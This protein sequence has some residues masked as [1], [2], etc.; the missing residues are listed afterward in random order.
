MTQPTFAGYRV[1]SEL[2]SGALSTV[3]K[4]TQDPLGRTV[5]I[6]VLKTT[7][8][9]RS[10]FA[11]QLEREAHVL[12]SLSHP[13]VAMLFDFVKS[14]SKMYLVLEYVDGYS[15]ADVAAKVSRLAPEVVAAIGVEIANGLAHAHARGIVHRDVK[16]ANVILSKRGDVKIA[17][18]G[19]AQRER[20]PSADEPL[21][22]IDES[23]AFGTPAYMSPEQILGEVVDAR[24]DIF[25]LGVVLYQL[26]CGARPFERGD[27][28]DKRA[29]AQRIR[30]DPPIPLHRRAPEVPRALERIV[31]RMVEK[32]P[33]DRYASA[34]TV[35][36]HLQELVASRT[37]APRADLVRRALSRAGLIEGDKPD[38]AS[39]VLDVQA[40]RASVRPTLIGLAAI[41]GLVV[42]GGGIVQFTG[43]GGSH[44]VTAGDRPLE[45]TPASP[46]FLRVLATPWAEVWVDGQRIDVT[47][48]ARAIPLPPGT[49]YVVLK[50][51]N[52]P[53]E[54][55]QVAIVTEETL[56]LDVS[57]S[58]DTE[59]VSLPPVDASARTADAPPT[60]APSASAKGSPR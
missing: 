36:D 25:S 47:P 32:L 58:L 10:P 16:P 50:H 51:P 48:F 26:L 60:A 59:P 37:R 7:I 3:Y 21:T 34:Q 57:M 14:E 23:A 5:A 40:R 24:S 43:R 53:P 38:V 1:V 41:F 18:F 9:P 42:V 45:L 56:T 4:A 54:K 55:R 11:A 17:D 52:A 30:R 2:G 39:P 15:L 35:A 20:L 33:I 49:H 22:K 13:N 29:A 44:R 46:G 12:S 28:K 8:D 6:K 31:M 19:I 27:E